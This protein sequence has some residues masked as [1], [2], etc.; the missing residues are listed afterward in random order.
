MKFTIKS[1]SGHGLCDSCRNATI[2]KMADE[3]HIMRCSE[4]E[5]FLKGKIIECNEYQPVGRLSDYEMEDKAWILEVKKGR[6]LGFKPPE[7]SE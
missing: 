7:Q 1:D 4:F 5:R 2:A 3:S 6:I